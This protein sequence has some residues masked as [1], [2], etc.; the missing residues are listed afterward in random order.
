MSRHFDKFIKNGIYSKEAC[1]LLA[2]DMMT[3]IGIT[4]YDSMIISTKLSKG[5]SWPNLNLS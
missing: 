3:K 4:Y 2:T 5:P 1:K